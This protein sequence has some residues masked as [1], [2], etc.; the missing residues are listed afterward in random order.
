MATATPGRTLPL[1]L[2]LAR[3]AAAVVEHL[4][5]LAVGQAALLGILGGQLDLRI[6]G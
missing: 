2:T 4:G 3:K 1:V 6:A 5:P